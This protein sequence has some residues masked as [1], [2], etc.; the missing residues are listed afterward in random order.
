MDYNNLNNFLQNLEIKEKLNSSTY[1]EKIRADF[2]IPHDN[3]N[4][5]LFT[6]TKMKDVVLERGLKLNNN[7][8]YNVEIANPQRFNNTC[9]KK[10]PND[11]NN[12]LNDYN[13][14]NFSHIY[15]DNNP[16]DV[17]DSFNI[18]TKN[19]KNNDIKNKLNT[20]DRI[21]EKAAFKYE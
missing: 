6:D 2:N 11:S 9:L 20:R 19:I 7:I 14:N 17:L 4:N 8:N 18:N 12:K 21:P 5:S 16:L 1:K 3:D 15:S 13:F 10:N